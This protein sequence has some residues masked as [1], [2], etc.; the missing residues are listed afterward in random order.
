M[1]KSFK[2]CLFT[3]EQPCMN[4]PTTP[5]QAVKQQLLELKKKPFTGKYLV[6]SLWCTANEALKDGEKPINVN[7]ADFY[8]K[9]ISAIEAHKSPE[10]TE[11]RSLNPQLSAGSG[12]SWV[13]N[14]AIFNMFI[15][16]TTAF[17]HNGDN[18]L[19]GSKADITL[20]ND[21]IRE[22]GTFLKAIA[23]LGYIKALGFSVIHL[24]PVTAIGRD[25]NKGALGSPYAIK[26]PYKIEP[27]LADPLLNLPCEVQFKAFVEAA[28]MLKIRVIAEFVFRTASK[29][30]DWAIEH[31]SWFY[32]VNENLADRSIT[33]TDL[34]KAAAQYGS[35][36][37]GAEELEII[38]QKVEANDF[39]DLPKPSAQYQAFFKR[40]PEENSVKLNKKGQIRGTSKNPLTGKTETVKIPGA[41]ADWPPDDNQPPWSDVS[42]LRMYLE[43]NTQN[44]E[45]N[46]IAYNTIRMYDTKLAQQERANKPLWQAI[47]GLVPYYQ[48]EYAIDGVM[49]DMGHALPVPLMRQIVAKAR[50]QDPDFAFLSENFEIKQDS[51]EAG[52]NAVV[53][54]AWWVE[55]RRDG[56]YNLLRHIGVEGVP[57][58]F[59]AAVENHNT[60]RAAAREGKE[61]YSRYAM[62]VNTLLPNSVPFI[63]SGQ[64]LGETMPVNTGLDFSDASLKE[65]KNAKLGLF[66][67]ACY[68]WNGR[69]PMLE[70]TKQVLKIRR[71]YSYIILQTYPD[72]FCT[73]LTGY[74]DVIA[75]IRRHEGQYLMVLFNRS[76]NKAF[77]GEIAMSWCVK[78]GQNEFKNLVANSFNAKSFEVK[79]Q[80]LLYK[81]KPGE[82]ACFYWN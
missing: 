50:L 39:N 26:N 18:T 2:I 52:Y 56:M 44:P 8:L 60:P 71:D 11:T 48:T 24:L 59:F 35:P 72:S 37:F 63:H 4:T 10:I 77:E 54:Y 41:F 36:I 16:L 5:L 78:A 28:H 55:Y 74:E 49:V 64:E 79:E 22:S 14:E 57:L 51:V 70:F 31:P 76:L 65:L 82:C 67:M 20:N 38:K 17:D 27:T 42:Y 40:P 66:D 33:E 81:L 9:H 69:H 12:G 30:S 45:F 68:N 62:L 34:N 53:G 73:L 1:L 15:R 46:Y 21:G 13:A 23:M 7:P 32:W 29:D 3:L 6:P 75:F 19:G 80:K 43:E 47:L 58:P 25:G 61:G